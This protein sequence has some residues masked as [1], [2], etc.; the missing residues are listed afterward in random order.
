M[1]VFFLCYVLIA[2]L[3]IP[4]AGI[5]T[6]FAGSLFGLITGIIIV[7]FASSIGAALAFLITRHFLG[8]Y[9]QKK[10]GTKLKDLNTKIQIEGKF[11]LFALRLIPEFPFFLVNI[12][13][14]LTKIPIWSFY[15]VSQLGMLPVTILFVNAGTRLGKIH[16]AKD[17]MSIGIILSLIALGLFPIIVK[18]FINYLRKKGLITHL[19]HKSN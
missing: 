9:I 12:L 7:S 8:D 16:S 18:W 19:F 11:Y 4:G 15:W 5:M 2:A 1:T 17:I 3:S 14:S 6:I 13:M 10:Y